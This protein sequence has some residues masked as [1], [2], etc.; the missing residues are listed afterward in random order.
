MMVAMF[1]GIGVPISIVVYGFRRGPLCGFF[2]LQQD[3]GWI[4]IAAEKDKN[5]RK[6]AE[7]KSEQEERMRGHRMRG[8]KTHSRERNAKMHCNDCDV[9]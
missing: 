5:T 1:D 7:N 8:K 6:A 3:R 9:G 2:A 4:L